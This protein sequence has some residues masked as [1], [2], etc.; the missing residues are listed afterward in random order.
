[1]DPIRIVII[2]DEAAIA[3]NLAHLLVEA[4][5]EYWI[6]TSLASVSESVQWLNTHPEQYDLLF[7]DIRLTDGQSFEIFK[8][9]LISKPVIFVT[10]YNDYAV[11]AF[12]NNGIDYV[13]KPFDLLEIQAA[14]SKYK[15]FFSSGQTPDESKP[16][17][18]LIEQIQQLSQTYKKAFLVHYREKLIPL[19]VAKI[20]WFYTANE[21][22]Y[23]QSFDNRQYVIENTLEQLE[24]QLDPANF[25]RAN[26]QFIVNRT[27]IYEVDFYFN[28][29]LCLQV[30]PVAPE[31][32]LI[33]KAR[34]PEFR[35]W[36]NS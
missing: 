9:V 13:L 21:I 33:S 16:I 12:K 18:G 1:M 25:F 6:I 15:K 34:V 11:Q 14:L 28:G 3:R 5:P 8:Q 17:H 7:M 30:N 35:D 22:V 29:R 27:A 20:S 31:Q 23:A 32:I 10:A 19:E 26:R 2:E 36:M 4:G 24:K